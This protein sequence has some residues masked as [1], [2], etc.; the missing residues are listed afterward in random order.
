MHPAKRTDF[1][2]LET[3]LDAWRRQETAR[4]KAAGL[5]PDKE[6]VGLAEGALLWSKQVLLS[7]PSHVALQILIDPKSKLGLYLY[8][9]VDLQSHKH[10]TCCQQVHGACMASAL[11]VNAALAG[12]TA[13]LLCPIPGC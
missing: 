4:I 8:P 12:P 9:G 6:Q 5:G 3:E 1:Q 11:P 13:A 7:G 10:A 2:V